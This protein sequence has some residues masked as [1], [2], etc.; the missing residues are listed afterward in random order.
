[1]F[2]KRILIA[3]GA[4]VLFGCVVFGAMHMSNHNTT[5]NNS[6]DAVSTNQESEVI[7]LGESATIDS[8]LQLN[9]DNNKGNVNKEDN[10]VFS[11]LTISVTDKD[12]DYYTK[13]T[14]DMGYISVADKET[15]KTLCEDLLTLKKGKK[16]IQYII[17]EKGM[18]DELAE[19]MNNL[20]D[21]ENGD[22]KSI[23]KRDRYLFEALGMDY[24]KYYSDGVA[25][26]M[27]K[28]MQDIENNT[29]SYSVY[30]VYYYSYTTREQLLLQDDVVKDI[31][32]AFTGTKY[33]KV[34]AAHEYLRS[35][36]NYVDGDDYLYH[37]AYSALI[38]KEAVCEGY[39]KAYKVL[40]NSMDIPCEIVINEDHA[41]NEVKLN[42][43]WY[44]VD[45]TNDDAKESLNYF[46]VGLD[47]LKN[48]SGMWDYFGYG[49]DN[50][51]SR[52]QI[53]GE[54]FCE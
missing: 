48:E 36:V 23:D 31:T 29:G 22:Y 24:Q 10:T 52:N 46:L 32:K 7:K 4:A 8:D 9:I 34:L 3:A 50:N 15:L 39:A 38:N 41:W 16:H 37:T 20:K 19:G 13:L 35:H 1:M 12:Y 40:L 51:T 54:G 26:F 49:S 42:G 17:T 11:F 28:K 33:D 44:V 18:F 47:F 45:V 6:G 21:V 14:N 5:H 27:I 2:N 30:A 25:L 53:S 43:K